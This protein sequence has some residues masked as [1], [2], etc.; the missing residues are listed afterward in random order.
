VCWHLRSVNQNRYDWNVPRNEPLDFY[1]HEIA[2]IIDSA[3]SPVADAKPPSTD[4]Y[5]CSVTP[6]K[7]LIKCFNEI[8]TRR[9]AL[10]DEE[11]I[12][13]EKALEFLDEAVHEFGCVVTVADENVFQ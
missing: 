3:V 12:I 13:G 1:P 4:H 2:R 11:T 9:Y 10:I 5:E 6:L 8:G 7:R